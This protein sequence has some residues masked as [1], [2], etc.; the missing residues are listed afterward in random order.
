MLKTTLCSL[1]LI[2]LVVTQ[3]GCDSP[4]LPTNEM[5]WTI[6]T[7]EG[8]RRAANDGSSESMTVRVESLP[9][10]QGQLEILRVVGD[11]LLYTG[12]VVRHR[13]SESGK[14]TMVY[15]N[16]PGRK[17]SRLEGEITGDHSTWRTGDRTR[18]R[19]SR[20][21]SERLGPD[22]WKKTQYISEDEG[23]TWRE[24]FTDK[25]ERFE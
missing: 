13:D 21:V 16:S 8:T 9:D 15:V 4:S 22:K 23:A 1:L 10:G 24:L 17:F 19:I 7:W 25:L 6:G 2:S 11:S 18:R 3:P 5:S 14:W 20:L 12:F